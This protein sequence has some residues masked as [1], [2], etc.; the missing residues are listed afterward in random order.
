MLDRVK[1]LRKIQLQQDKWPLGGLGLMIVL[2]TPSEA[3]LNG[4]TFEKTILDAIDYFL[5]NILQKDLG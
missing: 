5:D 1:S 3:I 4:Y 2:D